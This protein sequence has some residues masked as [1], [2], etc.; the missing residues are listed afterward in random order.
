MPTTNQWEFTPKQLQIKR[1][2]HYVWANYLKNWSTNN[3]DVW[4]T[5]KKFK[6]AC[7]SVKAIA[8]EKDLYQARHL[9]NEQLQF[10]LQLSAQSPEALQ[11]IH[12]SFL[13]PFIQILE[14]EKFYLS[15]ITD[16]KQIKAHIEAI[17]SN[18]LENIHTAIENNVNKILE[19]LQKKNLK[20]L[21][22]LENMINFM[23]F[24]GH[25]I[26]R[27][28]PFRNK[29]LATQT[30]STVQ[31]IYKDSWWFISYMFGMNIGVDFFKT[32]KIDKHCLLINISDEDFITSD[33][34][35][36]NVHPNI[37]END[38][39]APSSEEADFFYPISPRIA[40][41]INKSDLF[42]SGISHVSID[43][44]KA[45]NRKLAIHSD[46]YIISTTETQLRTYKK[47]VGQRLKIIKESHESFNNI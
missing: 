6:I 5:T 15:S 31:T 38:L 36:I 17:K 21:D 9:S 26:A 25:Q 8:K 27:T 23:N 43:F 19:E 37:N 29:I 30:N 12:K 18:T 13:D 24:F 14:I 3:S 28:A 42:P 40:Y 39:N 22:E 11:K 2:N 1:E 16:N 44:V 41:M 32:R 34:P 33:H 20:I 46:Q 4:Y 35:I 10:I 7:D 47:F 45:M